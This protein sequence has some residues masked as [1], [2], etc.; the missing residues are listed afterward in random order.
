MIIYVAG[1][2]RAKTIFGKI[3]N[4]IKAY[5]TA[6]RI[7]NKGFIVFCPHMNTALFDIFCKHDDEFWLKAG[8][9]FLAKCDA[10]YMMKGWE[11]SKGS[12]D[13][14]L[15]A[16]EIHNIPVYYSIEDIDVLREES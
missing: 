15:D 13:E 4:I 11:N 10:I 14:N 12:I 7:S 8:R 3:L 9:E 1:H 16:T 6:I 2:Y 5:I